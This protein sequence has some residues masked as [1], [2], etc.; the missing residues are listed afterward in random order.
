M[1][2]IKKYQKGGYL[3]RSFFRGVNPTKDVPSDL[4]G[5]ISKGSELLGGLLGEKRVIPDKV[6]EAAWAQRLNQ[7]Y[8]SKYLPQN[9]DGTFRLPDDVAK[10]INFDTLDIKNKINLYEKIINSDFGSEYSEDNRLNAKGNLPKLNEYLSKLRDAYKGNHVVVNEFE[11]RKGA[12]DDYGYLNSEDT[13]LNVMGN[14]TIWYN[15]DEDAKKYQDIYDFNW[16]DKV[17][18]GKAFKIKGVIPKKQ[19]GGKIGQEFT[20]FGSRMLRGLQ[21]FGGSYIGDAIQGVSPKAANIVNKYTAGMIAPTPQEYLQK[22]RSGW[23]NKASSAMDAAS[24]I[25]AGEMI[26]P[27]AGKAI[28]KVSPSVPKIFSKPNIKANISQGGN[29]NPSLFAG[30]EETFRTPDDLLRV[31]K[32][33]K[34]SVQD[35]L[36]NSIIKET[37]ERN[38]KLSK[39]VNERMPYI[40]EEGIPRQVDNLYEFRRHNVERP[41][42]LKFDYTPKDVLATYTSAIPSMNKKS[43]ITA[44]W[45]HFG[46]KSI[47]PDKKLKGSIEHEL[48][49]HARFGESNIEQLKAEKLFK[50]RKELL[51]PESTSVKSSIGVGQDPEPYLLLRGEAATNMR[52]LA[53]DLGF[54]PGLKYPGKTEGM[55]I[56]NEVLGNY[57]G[58]KSFVINDLRLKT[59]RDYKRV[60]D[61]LTGR[62]FLIPTSVAGAST[63]EKK[64]SGGTLLNKSKELSSKTPTITP[65]L[66]NEEFAKIFQGI[67]NYNNFKNNSVSDT[68]GVREAFIKGNGIGRIYREEPINPLDTLSL[69]TTQGFSQYLNNI[70][71]K[72]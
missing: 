43:N 1:N 56:L 49:H 21:T 50:A 33:A 28:K 39:R 20:D 51:A 41:A 24:M 60:W 9:K 8:D 72:L 67:M 45:K 53:L 29:L 31:G 36:N 63:I 37:A 52:D 12:F 62:Y 58:G 17:V 32:E 35:Y 27:L 64:Q 10:Q 42:T 18:P 26:G 3:S 66:S 44:S 16:L 11:A 48:L 25:L 40:I 7:P 14:F 30:V 55:K 61:A 2:Y 70:N 23:N 71:K 38:T 6:A 59:P 4:I 47:F 22:N 57:K 15:K 65:T 34:L 46:R 13:P 19:S 69:N 54:S 68:T 5:Y